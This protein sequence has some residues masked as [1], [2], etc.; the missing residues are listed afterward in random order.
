MEILLIKFGFESSEVVGKFTM[1]GNNTAKSEDIYIGVCV[2]RCSK[3]MHILVYT[4]FMVIFQIVL[5]GIK[6]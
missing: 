2:H 6:E 1:S 5:K 3:A 4:I